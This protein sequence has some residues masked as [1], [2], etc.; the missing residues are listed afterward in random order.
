[1]STNYFNTL[2]AVADDCPVTAAEIP[3]VRS[4]SPTVAQLQYDMLVD[5]PYKLT[6]DDLLFEVHAQRL[7]IA[8]E[9]RPAKKERFLAQPLPCLR[10]SPLAKRYGWGFH[11]D[12]EG[13]VAIHPME[14]ETYES[15]RQ[16]NSLTQL[17]AMRSRRK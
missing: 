12:D 7:G 2:I 11:F 4:G 3:P 9:D 6:S 14:S 17:K 5:R 16:Q 8:V 15:M 1:M 13:R 10:S